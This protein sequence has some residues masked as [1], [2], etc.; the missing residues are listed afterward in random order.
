M[1]KFLILFTMAA[2]VFSCGP[3]KVAKEARKTFDGSWTL[4]SVTYPNNPGEFNVTLFNTA[5]A[6]CFENSN[7]DFV[8][9]NNRGTYTVNGVGC[10]G[11]SNYFIWS[12]DEENTPSGVY[13][14]LLKPT[15][16]DYKSTTGNQGFR[17]N[18][19]SLSDTNM[20]WEQTVSLDG[21]PFT[22]RMNFT[23]N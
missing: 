6:S 8:S 4:N 14:F 20:V 5:S 11:G 21:S 19:K 17:L 7:W 10:D 15:N 13:D 12:I 16:E 23:K 9:N 3:S 2:L 18:L 22:I 1:K